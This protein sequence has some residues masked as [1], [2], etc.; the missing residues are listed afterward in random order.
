M[1]PLPRQGW[2]FNWIFLKWYFSK[3]WQ[4]R[5]RQ[6]FAQTVT[7][8][9]TYGQTYVYQLILALCTVKCRKVYGNNRLNIK[10]QNIPTAHKTKFSHSRLRTY[11]FMNMCIAM[12]MYMI[13]TNR[14]VCDFC[15]NI[16]LGQVV[17]WGERCRIKHLPTRLYLAIVKEE[18]DHKV[19]ILIH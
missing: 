10:T 17:S 19:H 8:A 14:I 11:L 2:F 7:Y 9:Y 4:V 13:Y 18:S 12:H 5:T 15:A 1:T 6:V 3:Y 16:Q